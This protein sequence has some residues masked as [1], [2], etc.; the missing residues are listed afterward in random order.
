MVAAEAAVAAAAEL[1]TIGYEATTFAAVRDALL[2]KGVRRLID[3]RAL[4]SSRKPGFSKNLLASS[5]LAAGIDY[6]HLRPLGTPKPGRDAVRR[7]D[8]AT[9]H[10]IFADHMTGLEPRAALHAAVVAARETSACL[11]C[12]ERDHSTCHRTLVAE[13]VAAETG[14]AIHHLT[15]ELPA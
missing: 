10:R 7:G 15:P 1:L 9:M 2:V 13:M 3:V 5:L 8:V 14:Q 12:F 6:V 4:P 11:L